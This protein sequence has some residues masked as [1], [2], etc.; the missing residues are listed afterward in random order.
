MINPFVCG[1]FPPEVEEDHEPTSPCFSPRKNKKTSMSRS[2]GGHN[3]NKNPYAL[4]GLDKFNMLLAELEEKRQQ[5]YSQKGSDGISLVRFVYPESNDC[6]P[7]VVKLKDKDKHKQN[8]SRD[9]IKDKPVEEKSVDKFPVNSSASAMESNENAKDQK[10][11]KKKFS[12]DT[13]IN[14]WSRPAYYLPAILILI[15]LFMA[16][17]GRSVAVL[18]TSVGWYLVPSIQ[19]G[20]SNP[21][22]SMKKKKVYER[23]FSEIKVSNNNKSGDGKDKSPGKHGHQK[24]W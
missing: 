1:T 21:R 4:R 19:G 24:S 2:N 22:K 9:R 5:I 7:I 6:V 10:K 20:N 3:K 13:E 11:T 18:C 14:R 15:L 17:F 12:W 8:K 23:R 16:V